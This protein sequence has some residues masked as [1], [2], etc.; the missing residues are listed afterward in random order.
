MTKKKTT[1]SRSTAATPKSKTAASQEKP[2]VSEVYDKLKETANNPEPK[3][4]KQAKVNSW[5]VKD[6]TY[7][8]KGNSHPLSLKLQTRGIF[9][10]DEDAGY[11][12]ELLYTR[13]QRTVFV[14]EMSGEK[15]TAHVVF[16]NGVLTVPR[17]MQTLQKLLSIYHPHRNRL[18]Y[19]RDVVAEAEDEFDILE[20]ELEAMNLARNMEIDEAEAILRVEV[21]SAVS[22]MSSKEIKRDVLLFAKRKPDLF[23]DLVNDPNI[24]L[25]N[26]G[27]KA[28]EEGIL[29]L[30]KDN[31]TFKWGSTGRSLLQVP[32]DEHPYSALASWFKT[33]EGM[34]VLNS[35]EKR[36]A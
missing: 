12:R 29:Q 11:E 30:S 14:D 13:N 9:Y 18:Y 21:G 3:P 20:M 7:I 31:R 4:A 15:R 10:F 23:I 35:I 24:H 2:Q 32:F 17:N 28:T 6:R 5:E 36:M 22:K 33:D 34:E 19:E 25:R 16:R 1:P 26:I 8:L 27:I